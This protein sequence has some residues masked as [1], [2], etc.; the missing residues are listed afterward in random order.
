MSGYLEQ[1][2]NQPKS[3]LNWLLFFSYTNSL[4]LLLDVSVSS[5]LKFYKLNAI[6]IPYIRLFKLLILKV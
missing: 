1:K 2:T 6:I 3:N 4:M 5:D